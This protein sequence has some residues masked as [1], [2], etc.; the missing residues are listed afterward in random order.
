MVRRMKTFGIKLLGSADW[1]RG[2]SLVVEVG[3]QIN[4]GFNLGMFQTNT[5]LVRPGCPRNLH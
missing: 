2:Q 4:K 3:Y 5:A 1:E